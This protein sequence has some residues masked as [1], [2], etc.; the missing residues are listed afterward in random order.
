MQLIQVGFNLYECNIMHGIAFM[1][2]NLIEE[3]LKCLLFHI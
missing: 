1:V 3:K 2:L